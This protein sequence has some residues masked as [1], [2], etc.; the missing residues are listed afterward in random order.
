MRCQRA[1]RGPAYSDPSL[2]VVPK[3]LGEVG[4][5]ARGLKRKKGSGKTK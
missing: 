5:F 2:P 1:K 3:L 4:A